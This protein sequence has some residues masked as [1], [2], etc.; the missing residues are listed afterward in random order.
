MLNRRL[1]H[2][3]IL[4]TFL[5]FLFVPQTS[6][7]ESQ[8]QDTKSFLWEVK[9]QSTTAFIL[10][11]IHFANE[12]F[13]PL[14]KNIEEAF[15][16]SSTLVVELNP[17]T[18]DEVKMN[19]LILKKG[20]YEGDETIFNNTTKE[21]LNLLQKYLTKNNVPPQN[22]AKLKPAMIAITISAVQLINMGFTPEFGIDMYF[23]QKAKESKSIIEL[24]SME[25]QLSLLFDMPDEELFLKYTLLE[26]EQTE[27][28]FGDIIE[29]WRKGDLIGMDN[30]ILKPYEKHREL[31]PLIK[32]LF[33]ERNIKM[34]SRIKELL[35][36]NQ[37]FFVVVGAGHLVGEFGIL[38]LLQS[39][40]YQ[41][42]Q[43]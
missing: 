23:C 9:S 7:T 33:Y 25:E 18:V 38:N 10:G 19:K 24:E 40:N 8:H 12:S 29:S 27:K 6:A 17:L 16:N 32:K 15:A 5:I 35:K 13:Y 34:A 2:Y 14:N 39:E 4:F 3:L 20:V 28:I 41:I 1:F 11:S 43:L 36:G 37:K 21:T 26:I 30:A 31:N 22:I 42:Q